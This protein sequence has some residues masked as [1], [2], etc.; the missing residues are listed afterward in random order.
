MPMS[1]DSD[2]GLSDT[3]LEWGMP[4][5]KN[6]NKHKKKVKK[7]SGTEKYRIM[8]LRWGWTYPMHNIVVK[9]SNKNAQKSNKNAQ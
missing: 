9:K 5:K 3:T 8:R 6:K 1:H 2:D 4:L 7:N